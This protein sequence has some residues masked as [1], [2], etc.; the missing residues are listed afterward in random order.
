[1]PTR[2]ACEQVNNDMVQIPDKQTVKLKATDT[3]DEAKSN[4]Q[5]K[6]K[7]ASRVGMAEQRLQF[8]RRV[9]SRRVFS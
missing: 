3:I 6:K 5:W 8:D 9:R 7:R 1:M 4:Q 2:N